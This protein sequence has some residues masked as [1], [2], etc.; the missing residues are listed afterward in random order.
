M[1][2]A[3]NTLNSGMCRC[4]SSEGTFK[5]IKTTYRWMGEEEVYAEMLTDCFDIKIQ[6]PEDM[7]NGICELCITQLRNALNFKKQVLH[8]EEQFKRRMQGR[9][10]K[11]PIKIES[12]EDSIESDHL[13][14]QDFTEEYEVPIKVE[15][16]EKPKAK[17]RPAKP[18]TPRAKKAKSEPE[19]S[20]RV[21]K[22]S[23]VKV[24]WKRKNKDDTPGSIASAVKDEKAE[25]ER[26]NERTA[27]R[28]RASKRETNKINQKPIEIHMHRHN[29]RE[30]LAS[31]NAT[32]IRCHGD[33]GYTCCFCPKQFPRPA[34]LKNHTIQ[35]HDHKT[36]QTFMADGVMHSYIVKLDIT[37]L[38]CELCATNLDS[39]DQMV[40]HLIKC[41][42]KKLYTDIKNHILPFKFE[43]DKMRCVICKVECNSFKHLQEHMIVHFRNYVC[44][45]CDSGFINRRMQGAH[46][47]THLTGKFECSTCSKV[48]D[49]V[50][51]LKSHE[52]Q[53]HTTI[54]YNKCGHCSEKFKDFK[55][56]RKHLEDVHGIKK[57][58]SKCKA[59]DKSFSSLSALGV[60]VKRNHLIE[61]HHKCGQCDMAF[62]SIREL[63]QHLVKHSGTRE[64]QCD[65]CYKF[66]GLRKTL[67]EHM[68]I[69]TNDRRFEC[70]HCG[71]TF[72]QKCSLK[73]HLRSKHS[74]ST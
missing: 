63:E 55:Q 64:F 73:G 42:R 47:K 19:S 27:I 20:Q 62:Y 51:K 68:R 33:I 65:V 23:F 53:V 48:F 35:E 28:K 3:Q 61:R 30:I 22:T 29:I 37:S 39:L 57:E 5:D 9:D 49:T 67:V 14:D 12:V 16:E 52:R 6:T 59:C 32:P 46:A 74:E 71:M 21:M 4:C 36:K 17:K 15:I 11:N 43:D 56:K 34:D 45:V 8:T 58:K 41:H 31:S 25:S 13:S 26:N 38:R 72:V 70:P 44:D 66:Y 1:M 24:E 60:H 2:E 7:D 10:V 18:A 40:H 50:L 54:M 69:H